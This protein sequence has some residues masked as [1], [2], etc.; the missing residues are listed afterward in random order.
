[1]VDLRRRT[2]H[3]GMAPDEHRIVDR[4]A[5]R[6]AMLGDERDLLR[7]RA[8]LDPAHGHAVEEHLPRIGFAQTHQT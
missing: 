4:K 1:M 2:L 3:K 5:V 8:P 7:P 6:V